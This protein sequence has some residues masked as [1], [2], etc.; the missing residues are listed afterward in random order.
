VCLKL[1]GFFEKMIFGRKIPKCSR[2][3]PYLDSSHSVSPLL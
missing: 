3:E 2:F 1:R